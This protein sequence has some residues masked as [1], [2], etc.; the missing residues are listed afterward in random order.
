MSILGWM[1]LFEEPMST[2]VLSLLCIVLAL[3]ALYYWFRAN[4]GKG[5]EGEPPTKPL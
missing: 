4:Q 5:S 1:G 3:V 2:Q